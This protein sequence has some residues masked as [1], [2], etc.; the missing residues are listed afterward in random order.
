MLKRVEIRRATWPLQYIPLFYLQKLLGYFCCMFWVSVCL[1][2]EAPPNR[3]CCIWLNLGRQYIPIDFIIILAASV[4]CHI[5]NKH[6]LPSATGS[7]ARS[8]HHTAPLCFTD[9]VVWFWSWA[10]QSLFRTF[11]FPSFWNRLILISAVQR[12]LFQK[13]F[14]R[15]FSAKS[16][17]VCTL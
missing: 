2:H 9:D 14:F 13:R 11:F 6:Y 17:L 7:H 1:Y 8:C 5:I 10:F 12:M 16:G 15:C 4:L 3:L